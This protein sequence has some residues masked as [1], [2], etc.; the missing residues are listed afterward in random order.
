MKKSIIWSIVALVGGYVICQAIA[1]V[2]ATKFVQV[3]G[4]TIPAGT[5]IFALTFTLRDMLHKKLGKEWARAAIVCAGVFNVAQAGYLYGV[6]RLP[7][8]VFFANAGAWNSIFA[9]V[10]SITV[11]SITAEIISELIDTEVYHFWLT[12]FPSLPQWS[13]VLVSNAVSLPIDSLVFAVLAFSVLPL[14]MGGGSVSI[15]V[16]LGLTSGQIVYKALVT[17]ISLPCIYLVD[18]KSISFCDC[19]SP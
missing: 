5:F 3:A 4:V 11:A 10:P 12:R 7:S 2:G 14:V 8:P 1:D 9:I 15:A 16:A 6:S 17:V 19:V 18:D 13:R